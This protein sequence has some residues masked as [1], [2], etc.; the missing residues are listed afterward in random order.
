[1]VNGSS[2]L[3]S[4]F[5]NSLDLPLFSPLPLRDVSKPNDDYCRQMIPRMLNDNRW[6]GYLHDVELIQAMN[7]NARKPRKAN[8]GSR[9]ASRVSRRR[10]KEKIGKRK[11]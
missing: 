3:A 7:R 4:S 6:H 5:N 9:P 10:K 2:D 8:K 11:R 1:M